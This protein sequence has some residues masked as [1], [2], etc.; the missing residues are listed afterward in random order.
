LRQN[1]ADE[2]VRYLEPALAFYQQGGYRSEA[3]SCL[4]LLARANRQK[5]DYDAALNSSAQ[6]LQ[7]GQ[8]SNDQSQIALAHSEMANV[9]MRQE[10]Y[11]EALDH[12][13]KAFELY[14]SQGIQRSIGYNLQARGEALAQLGRYA[15]AQTLLDQAAVI[16]DKPGAEI[17]PLSVAIMLVNAKSAL[18]AGS[19]PEAKTRAEKVREAAGTE[20]KEDATG[21]QIVIGL[22]E[23]YTGAAAAGK[24]TLTTA[25]EMAKQ[26]NDP[27]KLASAQLALAIASLLAGDSRAA[28]SNALQAEEVFA[29]LGQPASDWQALLIAAQASQNSGDKTKGHEYAMRATETF[30]KLE[31]RWGGEAYKTYLSRPD[32]QRFRKQLEQ[33]NSAQ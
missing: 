20:F 31:Q 18:S 23:S 1:N 16:A 17:K 11:S 30:S 12:F 6:I 29:R 26:L 13:G 28:A 10:K 19:F 8:Q 24:Q 32:V 7:L 3:S 15:E 4:L 5:G 25:V 21:A 33:L 27:A 14:N 2:A 22:A 9:L